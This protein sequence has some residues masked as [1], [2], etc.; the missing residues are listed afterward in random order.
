MLRIVPLVT[1]VHTSEINLLRATYASAVML[2]SYACACAY[3]TLVRTQFNRICLI[4][5][6]NVYRTCVNQALQK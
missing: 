1:P 4:V 5:M 3:L 6:L 2:S